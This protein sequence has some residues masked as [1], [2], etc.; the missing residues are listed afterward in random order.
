MIKDTILDNTYRL[1]TGYD[2]ALVTYGI[3]W[4]K[5]QNGTDSPTDHS[6][7]NNYSVTITSKIDGIISEG[8]QRISPQ[9]QIYW[10]YSNSNTGWPGFSQAWDANDELAL[11]NKLADKFREHQ[12]STGIFVGELGEAVDMIADR[13]RQILAAAKAVKRGRLDIAAKVLTAGSQSGGSLDARTAKAIARN[14]RRIAEGKRTYNRSKDRN[15]DG[16]RFDS[17][18]LE[19]QWGWKPL[20][21]DVYELSKLIESTTGPRKKRIVARRRRNG[22]CYSGWP[23]VLEANGVAFT[24]MQIIAEIVEVDFPILDQIGLGDPLSVAWELT[25]FSAIVDYFVP[26]G[27]YLSARNFSRSVTGK[28]IKT[29]T[30]ESKGTLYLKPSYVSTSYPKAAVQTA[31]WM[32]IALTRTVSNSLS[33][34]MPRTRFA[35][36]ISKPLKVANVAALLSVIFLAV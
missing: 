33:V 26:I 17:A 35:D 7:Q 36:F 4:R 8:M 11:I 1:P 30:V 10:Y 25:P 5:N 21:S 20:L 6:V 28:F 3:Y 12:F 18:W 2:N 23:S 29:K 14:R 16:Q 15:L 34:P 22:T 9:G 31:T 13:G 24:K 19:L 32:Q 27:N